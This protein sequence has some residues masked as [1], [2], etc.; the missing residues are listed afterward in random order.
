MV[1]TAHEKEAHNYSYTTPQKTKTKEVN[2]E[3]DVGG[4]EDDGGKGGDGDE[5]GDL[6]LRAMGT[7]GRKQPVALCA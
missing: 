5:E 2:K 4:A 1:M 3:K 6:P 7:L